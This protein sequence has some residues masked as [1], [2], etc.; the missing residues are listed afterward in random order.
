[1]KS[2]LLTD[3]ARAMLALDRLNIRYCRLVVVV[4]V[5]GVHVCMCMCMFS[6][7]FTYLSPGSVHAVYCVA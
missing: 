7:S 2:C 6:C 3:C 1:M 5:V 4:V